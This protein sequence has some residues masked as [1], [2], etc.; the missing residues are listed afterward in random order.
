MFEALFILTTVDTGTRVARFL[1]QEMGGY[2]IKPLQQR[3]WIPGIIVTSVL[4]VAAWSYLIFSGSVSTIWP[5]F[6]V[7]NQLLAAIALG[8]G[9]VIIIKEGKTKYLWVTLIPMVFMFVT[10]FTASW[11]LWGI[12]MGKAAGAAKPADAVTFKIDAVLVLIMASLAAVV[13]VDMLI[14]G[15]RAWRG[16]SN[17]QIQ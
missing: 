12:F 13:L 3:S 16:N 6:G 14:K 4:V 11:E 7:T 1:L 15:Y 8:I 10:T 17:L 2:V 5:M 9:S